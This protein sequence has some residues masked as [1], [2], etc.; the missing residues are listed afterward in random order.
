[1]INIIQ[2]VDLSKKGKGGGE[3][4]NFSIGNSSIM[5]YRYTICMPVNG[6]IQNVL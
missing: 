1:M 4:H 3:N 2:G 6:A 5:L